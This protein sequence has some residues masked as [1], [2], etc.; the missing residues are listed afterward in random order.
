MDEN[1]SMQAGDF[2]E[3]RKGLAA[4]S[5]HPDE[6]NIS[7]EYEGQHG[8]ITAFFRGRVTEE[9]KQRLPEFRALKILEEKGEWKIVLYGSEEKT[10]VPFTQQDVDALCAA[11][12]FTLAE[13]KVPE[14]ADE[15]AAPE[16]AEGE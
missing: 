14:A 10:E 7:L 2:A 16:P 9:A 6:V 11:Y 12:D 8:A 15:E 5:S 1:I 4:D 13:H 3:L